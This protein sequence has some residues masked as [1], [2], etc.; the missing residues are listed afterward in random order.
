ME[1]T[2]TIDLDDKMMKSV[3]ESAANALFKPTDRYSTPPVGYRMMLEEVEKAARNLDLAS[4]ARDAAS[5]FAKGI[6]EEATR[7][8]LR[9]I[10]KEIV[11]AEKEAGSLLSNC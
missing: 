8:M 10:A 7:E 2:I 3:A 11:K 5:K 4:M 1:V 6:I 9:K